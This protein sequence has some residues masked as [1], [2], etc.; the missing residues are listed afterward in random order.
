LQSI[1]ALPAIAAT[2]HHK[3]RSVVWLVLGVEGGLAWLISHTPPEQINPFLGVNSRLLLLIAAFTLGILGVA[4]LIKR[5]PHFVANE[6]SF[7]QMPFYRAFIA[8]GMMIGLVTWGIYARQISIFSALLN[9]SPEERAMLTF[10]QTL[11]KDVLFAGTPCALDNVP[12]FGKREIVFSCETVSQDQSLT[13]EAL[14]AYYAEDAATV[15]NF[16]ENYNVA[17]L[18]L[19]NAAYTDE[20]LDKGKIFFPPYNDEILSLVRDRSTFILANV[21]DSAKL[22]HDGDWFIIP[23]RASIFDSF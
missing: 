17:Y 11:P 1:K 21:L 3:R 19:H 12:L 9:P 5:V 23:C 7:V 18:I 8:A 10:V 2:S 22:F 15:L 14:N 20:Y 6:R 13:R 16:C 4:R